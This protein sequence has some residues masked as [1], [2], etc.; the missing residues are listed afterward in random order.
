MVVMI[1]N[2]PKSPK[3]NKPNLQEKSMA[4]Q[5]QPMQSKIV[6]FLHF[7]SFHRKQY[8][9]KCA[10]SPGSIWSGPEPKGPL[11]SGRDPEPPCHAGGRLTLPLPKAKTPYLGRPPQREGE[12][13]KLL[14]WE[15]LSLGFDPISYAGCG[16]GWSTDSEAL[17]FS[18]VSRLICVR[19]CA[20][21]ACL[22]VVLT[23]SG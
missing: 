13:A 3:K 6:H 7:L 14:F 18:S 10:F 15:N 21:K 17:V 12:A 8:C 16:Q 20:C 4:A 2:Q 22:C 11:E 19:S 23:N 5:K 9:V 1:E